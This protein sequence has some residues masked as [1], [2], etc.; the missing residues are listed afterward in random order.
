MCDK[1]WQLLILSQLHATLEISYHYTTKIKQNLK[2]THCV[3]NFENY[4]VSLDSPFH[5]HQFGIQF[6]K[7]GFVLNKKTS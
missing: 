2:I 7:F 6:N 4:M 1:R 3:F 5:C